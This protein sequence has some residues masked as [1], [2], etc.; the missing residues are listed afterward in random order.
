MGT[1]WMALAYLLLTTAAPADDVNHFGHRALHIPINLDPAHKADIKELVLYLSKDEGRTWETAMRASPEKPGFDFAATA[2]GMHWFSIA[3]VNQKGEQVPPDPYKAPVGQ[4]VLIDTLKPVVKVLSAE[5]VGEEVQV[6]WEARDERPN[7][8]SLKLEYKV[9][10]LPTAQWTPLPISQ[11]GDRGNMRFRPG[12]AGDVTVRLTLKDM[13]E[14]VAS[15]EKVAAGRDI[16]LTAA[17]PGPS[18][19]GPGVPGPATTG[20]LGVP[21]T[22]M[23]GSGVPGTGGPTGFTSPPPPPPAT[24]STSSSAEAPPPL[25]GATSGH[26]SAPAGSVPPATSAMIPRGPLPDLLIVNKPQVKLGFDVEKFGP[27]GLGT[28]EV[29]CT[30]DEG[31]TWK[32]IR[33]DGPVTL[34]PTA[35]A[36][37]GQ[38]VSGSVS[39]TLSE[40]KVIYGLYLVVKNRVNLGE[41][42]PVPGDMPQ[43]RVELDRTPPVA[44]LHM[45]Q[46]EKGRPDSMVF[47]W[48][49]DD[50][51]LADNPITLEWSASGSGP[52]EPIGEAQLPNTGRFVWQVPSDRLPPKVYLKLTVRDR[53]G[54]SSVAQTPQPIPLDTTPP[55]LRPGSVRVLTGN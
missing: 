6:S 48:K 12:A 51:N 49:A 26:L 37:G 52:W 10:S 7:W 20:G 31:S 46:P 43:V 21:G 16:A 54:N 4:K 29:Y 28:V 35:E 3:V 50:R 24:A 33:P 8:A 17:G 39:V 23:P 25:I 47:T 55:R 27:S 53:A 44:E 13:A 18:M 11:P 19:P 32:Q 41:P 5:R 2:D 15:D 22:T 14:N 36:R 1:G 38:P 34:P 42:A 40:E 9:G 30:T 45:P